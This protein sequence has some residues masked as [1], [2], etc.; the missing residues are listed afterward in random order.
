MSGVSN[1]IAALSSEMERL[2]RRFERYK[3]F[4]Q[5]LVLPRPPTFAVR[6]V[7]YSLPRATASEDKLSVAS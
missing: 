1:D 5:R 4:F 3:C 7:E 6:G 2:Q